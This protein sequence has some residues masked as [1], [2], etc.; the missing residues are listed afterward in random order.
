MNLNGN[1][2]S[3][4]LLKPDLM[5]PNVVLTKSHCDVSASSFE[6]FNR[7]CHE[8]WMPSPSKLNNVTWRGQPNGA[9]VSYSNRT[10][11]AV[12]RVVHLIR[13]PLDNLVARK[14][15]AVRHKIREKA[16]TKQQ[17]ELFGSD[18][19]EG[20]H[21]WCQYLDSKTKERLPDDVKALL[22]DDRL[23]CVSDLYRYI[24]WHNYATLLPQK[25]ERIGKVHT[26]FYEDYT[27]NYDSTVD[28]LLDFLDLQPAQSPLPFVPSKTYKD[29]YSGEQVQ[30]IERFVREHASPYC[31]KMLSRYF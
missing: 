6:D 1:S 28:E 14:H 7:A 15:M 8:V 2:A 9:K 20:F 5:I 29:F 21:A 11:W 16:L 3:P 4:F 25:Q 18:T 17:A 13:S 24:W 19:A 10:F 23:P 30:A 27:S 22:S 26:L 31:M 12:R